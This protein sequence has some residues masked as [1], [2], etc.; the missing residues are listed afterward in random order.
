MLLQE[1][2]EVG[3]L[4]AVN[5]QNCGQ[6]GYRMWVVPQLFH[7]LKLLFR[8]GN[9]NPL[10]YSYLENSM[11]RG[12][13]RTTVQGVAKSRK[14]RL[15]TSTKL[16]LT[17]K[18]QQIGKYVLTSGCHIHSMTS[19]ECSWFLYPLTFHRPF[20]ALEEGHELTWVQGRS[21]RVSVVWARRTGR[22]VRLSVLGTVLFYAHIKNQFVGL[23]KNSFLKSF[24][25]FLEVRTE[26]L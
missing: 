5:E 7:I 3:H 26:Y 23:W 14:T 9:G 13:W 22:F 11:D 15:S 25:S 16:L 17:L 1:Y 21:R 20:E 12:A 18:I 19:L 6:A 2:Q 24:W 4:I 8:V 10:Q